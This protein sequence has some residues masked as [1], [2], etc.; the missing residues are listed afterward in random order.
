MV[1]VAHFE[2]VDYVVLSGM[3]CASLAIGIYFACFGGKQTTTKEYFKGD[4]KMGWIPVVFSMMATYIQSNGMLGIPAE[5]YNHGANFWFTWTGIIIGMPMA[6]YGFMPVFYD[7]EIT[8]IFQYVEM[9]FNKCMR[10]FSSLIGI[11]NMII[12]ASFFTYGP[13]IALNQATGLSV[14]GSVLTTTVIAAAY[15]SIGGIKAVMWVDAMQVIIALLAML[16]TIIKGCIDIGGISV[17]IDKCIEGGRLQPLSFS[18]DPRVRF[19]FWSLLIPN[20]LGWMQGYSTSQIQ[21]QRYVSCATKKQVERRI[22]L[23]L[24]GLV[25]LGTFYCFVGL[26]LYTAYW[27]CDPYNSQQIE[28][29]DQIFPLFVMQT[30]SSIPGMPGLF[31]AGV[32]SA[33]L[34]TTSSILNSLSAITLEDYIKPH[35]KS[36]SDSKATI[37]SKLIAIAYS[38]VCIL[39]VVVIMHSGGIVQ[40]IDYMG[41]ATVGANFALFTMCS[42]LGLTQS[43]LLGALLG[44]L[45]GISMGW[46]VSI[47]YQVYRP[48]S[49]PLPTSTANC[50]NVLG[51]AW[52][53]RPTSAPVSSDDIFDLYKISFFWM[54]PVSWFTAILT[55]SITSICIGSNEEF[56]L[57]LLSPLTRRVV[58]TFFKN[59]YNQ[60]LMLENERP[61]DSITKGIKSNPYK[62]ELKNIR[63]ITDDYK[64]PAAATNIVIKTSL[65]IFSCQFS[66]TFQLF[67]LFTM[68]AVARF[69]I[70][71]YVVLVLMLFASLAIGIYFACVGGKQTATKEYFKG[72][73]KMGWLPVVF[74]MMATYIESNGMLGIPAEVYNHGA[75]F[76]FTWTGILIGIPMA[77][78]GFMPVFYELDITS[79]YQYV[80]LRF[81]KYMRI[82]CSF[83]GIFN[84]IIQA[85]F[86]TYGPA[87]ALNQATGLSVWGSVLATTIIAAAYTSIG[88]IKAV[89]WVDAMQVIIA[90][91]AMLATIIK[92]CIDIGGISVIIDKCIEGG[93]LQ[94][95][96]FSLDPRIRFTFWS[97]FIPNTLG[98]MQGYSTSQIQVQR[99]VSCASRK[100]VENRIWL[101]LPGLVL[102]GT[103][104]C[105]VGLIL[106]T[107][108]WD[109]DPYN[110]QQI[111]QPDQIFPLFVMQTMTSMPGMPGLFVAGV[112]GAALS[113]TSSILNALSAVTLEDYIKPQWKSLSDKKATIL[114]KFIGFKFLIH[115]ACILVVLAIMHSGGIVQAIDY[116]GGA[117][118]GANFA[119]FTMGMFMPWV[120]TKGALLGMLCGIS[121]GWWVSIGYQIHRPSSSPL[122]TSTANCSNLLG[123]AWLPKPTSAPVSS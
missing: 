72:D 100:K 24:P 102:L 101:N 14:W 81:N 30:M 93:R 28:Q 43:C 103:F 61:S 17:V 98:W 21:V 106:Y 95:P 67:L 118:V 55:G 99:Y 75:N 92:G 3:L 48:P 119:L 56:G 6:I 122:P 115:V 15:T 107:A 96:S 88:G 29:P 63:P 112:F 46:W 2:I 51:E 76:W 35:W 26:I 65:R 64:N 109:C 16:A 11:F 94:P 120:N 80:D 57:K 34:S 52:L 19:T 121:M 38:L 89:M 113:S 12:Q 71:D 33:A 9:R 117:T 18:L 32:Y 45:C 22:W 108:Y 42:C 91:L 79:I 114:A 90:L 36:L 1:S 39:M 116:M 73:G 68:N 49:S 10:I 20:T 23:N 104:Y 50:S 83:I 8:S 123:E 4:S 58:K 82:L 59:K 40:A 70:A 31:V 84:M 37:L 111:E 27:D 97:L 87:I 62:V 78:Y 66:I 25:L 60:M 85:S 44:M 77:I 47:G 41:G 7:L 105:F 53:P 74:S 110:S 69:G 13:A 86:F 5:V 54:M